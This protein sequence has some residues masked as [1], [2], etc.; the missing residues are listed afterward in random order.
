MSLPLRVLL[1]LAIGALIV[2]LFAAAVPQTTD[3]FPPETMPSPG[4][5]S[6]GVV[7]PQIVEPVCGAD[8]RTYGNRCEAEGQAGVAVAHEGPCDGQPIAPP[9]EMGEIS[10][11]ASPATP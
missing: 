1:L 5:G 6:N 8:G 9:G 2:L 3:E 7:C 4:P 10:D 11:A